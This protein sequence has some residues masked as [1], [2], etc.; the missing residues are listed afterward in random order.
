MVEWK[1]KHKQEG[2]N[3]TKKRKEN[4]RKLYVLPKNIKVKGVIEQLISKIMISTSPMES[5]IFY[6]GSV[7][8]SDHI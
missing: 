5:L 1:T 2:Q 7:M 8:S 3:I 4:G 6:V